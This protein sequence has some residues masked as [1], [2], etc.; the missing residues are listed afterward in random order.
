MFNP[1]AGARAFGAS[2]IGAVFAGAAA[3]IGLVLLSQALVGGLSRLV[4]AEWAMAAVG[5]VLVAPLAIAGLMVGRTSAKAR[6]QRAAA[7][8]SGPS[9]DQTFTLAAVNA[10]IGRLYARSPLLAM[11]LA[12]AAGILAARLPAA[13]TFLAQ[14]LHQMMDRPEAEPG[15]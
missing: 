10:L 1:A 4:G 9:L 6:E 12:V 8:A 14:A 5:V 3:V 15:R 11:A 2:A 13:L 7:A